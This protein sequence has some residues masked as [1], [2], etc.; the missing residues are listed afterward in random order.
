MSPLSFSSASPFVSL[1]CFVDLISGF[2][3]MGTLT[4]KSILTL[5][6]ALMLAPPAAMGTPNIVLI[7]A[8]DLGC[9][10]LKSLVPDRS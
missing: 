7:L 5:F 9:G 10:T 8:D 3:M 6:A 4:M 1:V 2:R